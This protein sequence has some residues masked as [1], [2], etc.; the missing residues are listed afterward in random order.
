MEEG[1]LSN[2]IF[3]ALVLIVSIMIVGL[4]L[5]LLASLAY[6]LQQEDI[7]CQIGNSFWI[8]K[9]GCL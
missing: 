3:I 4:V 5:I 9:G 6:P 2:V 8:D 1:Q 7:S